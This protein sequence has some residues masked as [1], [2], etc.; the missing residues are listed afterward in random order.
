[1]TKDI[2]SN[3]SLDRNNHDM[4]LIQNSIHCINH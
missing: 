4:T 1:M 3:R 2:K